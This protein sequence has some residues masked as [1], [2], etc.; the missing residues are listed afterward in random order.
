MKTRAVLISMALAFL[1]GC[2]TDEPEVVEHSPASI[3]MCSESLLALM[4]SEDIAREHCAVYGQVALAH[5]EVVPSCSHTNF[6]EAEGFMQ[7]YLCVAP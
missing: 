2:A 3:T 1:T 4:S 7:E 6:Y 5:G